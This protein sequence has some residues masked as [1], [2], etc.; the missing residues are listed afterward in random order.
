MEQQLGDRNSELARDKETIKELLQRLAEEQV[1]QDEL[2]EIQSQTST[3]SKKLV[4]FETRQKE[5]K[6]ASDEGQAAT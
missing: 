4:D 5:Q 6:V 3:I 1:C 2:K